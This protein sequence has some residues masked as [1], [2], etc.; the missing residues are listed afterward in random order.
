M[1]P[2]KLE[3]EVQTDRKKAKRKIKVL[4]GSKEGET[5]IAG[6]RDQRCL[7]RW[8]EGTDSCSATE[9]YP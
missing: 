4:L 8:G 7:Q 3:K 5:D 9:R 2:V 6:D 1:M